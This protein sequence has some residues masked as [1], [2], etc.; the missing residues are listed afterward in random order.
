MGSAPQA[1]LKKVL[2]HFS[3][4]QAMAKP[5]APLHSRPPRLTL[6]RAQKSNKATVTLRPHK[7]PCRNLLPGASPATA[8]RSSSGTAGWERTC[9]PRHCPRAGQSPAPHPA[10]PEPARTSQPVCPSFSRLS[11][12]QGT[13][14]SG[15][16]APSR[17]AEAEAPGRR[18]C[19]L[20]R[21]CSRSAEIRQSWGFWGQA[22]GHDRTGLKPSIQSLPFS[23]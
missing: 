20:L 16:A 2:N 19:A 9:C 13:G 5:A 21:N 7:R 10:A 4:F 22:M 18:E 12:A 17:G 14:S 15:R 23:L 8:P 3:S 1:I 6:P 11:P